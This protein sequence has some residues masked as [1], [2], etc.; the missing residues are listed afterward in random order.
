M[1]K[2]DIKRAVSDGKRVTFSYC[3]NA[4]LYFTTEFDET[5]P[6]DISDMG[7]STFNADEKAILL[8]R[9]MRQFNKSLEQ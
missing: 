2:I 6:V 9:Y 8:M 1:V 3:R 4:M 7:E 5:F